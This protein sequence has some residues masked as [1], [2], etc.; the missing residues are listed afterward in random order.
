[1]KTLNVINSDVINGNGI[2]T[3]DQSYDSNGEHKKIEHGNYN[4][5]TIRNH[6]F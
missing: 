4:E 2:N 5:I 6:C 1:M 3:Y